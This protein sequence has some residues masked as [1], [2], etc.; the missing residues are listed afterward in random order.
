MIQHPN[1]TN[2]QL[3]YCSKHIC[4]IFNTNDFTLN[5]LFSEML[6]NLEMASLYW[7]FN[8]IL[9]RQDPVMVTWTLSITTS[10]SP[11]KLCTCS[12]ASFFLHQ[13]PGVGIS[14]CMMSA[15]AAARSRA[16]RC[17]GAAHTSVERLCISTQ[18]SWKTPPEV[19]NF[20]WPSRCGCSIVHGELTDERLQV[21]DDQPPP[22]LHKVPLSLKAH[23]ESQAQPGQGLSVPPNRWPRSDPSE[24][25]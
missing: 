1:H 11:P 17:S 24:V 4:R 2:K 14:L 10:L 9:Q 16:P 18:L 5:T 23:M 12:R 13:I 21:G 3:N 19:C 8:E 6:N 25:T 7:A 15:A 22:V 20:V